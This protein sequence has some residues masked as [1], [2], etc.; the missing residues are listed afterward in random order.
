MRWK[1]EKSY[2]QQ[3]IKKSE[4]C[5]SAL[6]GLC[7]ICM[8]SY[9]FY[10]T[11]L[12]AIL[13]SPYLIRYFKSWKK[14][15]IYKKKQEFQ[16]QFKEAI[17]SMSAALNVG[18]SVENAIRETWMD[19]QHLYKKDERIV[20]EFQYMSRQLDMHLPVE[21]ILKEFANRV[22]DEDV[23]TFVTVFSMAKKTGG[24]MVEIIKNASYQIGEKIDVKREIDTM[25][26]AKR[27][28]F[29]IMSGIPFVM[30]CY[31]KMSF[32]TFMQVLYGNSLGWIVMTVCLLI[33]VGAFELG[34]KIIEIEV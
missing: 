1:R 4:Y 17:S 20:Q 15:I 16:L 5:K 9:L 13:L 23:Q 6:L 25:L 3:G 26:A 21:R 8:V 18:Y 34:K 7:L 31:L 22:E 2:W 19:M 24:D 12:C 14:Q 28:E 11:V 30:I 32:P 10:G 29:R 33:Y 27:L